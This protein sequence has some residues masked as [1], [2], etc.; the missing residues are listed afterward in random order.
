MCCVPPCLGYQQ[1]RAS[2]QEHEVV[3]DL[4]SSI[5]LSLLIGQESRVPMVLVMIPTP[6]DARTGNSH[7]SSNPAPNV[8][9]L[10]SLHKIDD[11]IL[12]WNKRLISTNLRFHLLVDL[13]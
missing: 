13:T 5:A 7:F 12:A 2:I 11:L 3:K 6:T 4:F 9:S 1:D 8:S 10:T